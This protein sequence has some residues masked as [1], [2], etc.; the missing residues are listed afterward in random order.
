MK[1]YSADKRE[2]NNIEAMVQ[3]SALKREMQPYEMMSRTAH[4]G[5]F[6]PK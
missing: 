4:P 6:P 1:S 3:T 2:S 5:I